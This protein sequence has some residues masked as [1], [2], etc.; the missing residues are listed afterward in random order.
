MEANKNYQLRIQK[1]SEL[2]EEIAKKELLVTNGEYWMKCKLQY[3]SENTSIK[4]CWI[5]EITHFAILP[6]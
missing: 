6:E 2:T 1:I 3:N 4:A 5:D